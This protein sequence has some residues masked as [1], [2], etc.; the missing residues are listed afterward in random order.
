MITKEI[1][2]IRCE[3]LTKELK[4]DVLKEAERLLN[5]G[6]VDVREYQDNFVLPKLLMV[7][8]LRNV[9]DGLSP[10]SWNKNYAK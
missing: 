1:V 8:A 4:S 7:T 2:L 6:A 9:A 5:S 3:E 10:V